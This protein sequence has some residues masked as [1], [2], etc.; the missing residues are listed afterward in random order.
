MKI[1]IFDDRND[2][3]H[4][5]LNGFRRISLFISIYLNMPIMQ[6]NRRNHRIWNCL[7]VGKSRINWLSW[8]IASPS[9]HWNHFN[10]LVF[11]FLLFCFIRFRTSFSFFSFS[12][13]LYIL[14]FLFVFSNFLLSLFFSYSPICFLFLSFCLFLSS[15]LISFPLFLCCFA[16]FIHCNQIN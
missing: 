12:T 4:V 3:Y 14:L 10:I 13:F 9:I 5:Q 16:L 7:K 11:E 8:M 1:S 15:S 2:G 6:N